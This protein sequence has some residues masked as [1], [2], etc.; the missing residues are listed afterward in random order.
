MVP[1]KRITSSNTGFAPF[2]VPRRLIYDQGG[3]FEREFGQ[4]LKDMGCHTWDTTFFSCLAV[5]KR[6]LRRHH[7]KVVHEERRRLSRQ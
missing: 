7:I 6:C 3:D 5:T 4:E 2:G 1:S